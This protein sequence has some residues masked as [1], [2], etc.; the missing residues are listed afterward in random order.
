M[1]KARAFTL[2][3][4][5]VVIAIIALL[6]G[7]LLPA[8]SKARESA[9][10]TICTTNMR[11]VGIAFNTYA[12]DNKEQGWETGNPAPIFRF[13]YAM[14]R[15]QTRA[16]D[17][18][19]N[20]IEIGPGLKYLN[21]SDKPLECPTN[22]RAM[23][24]TGVAGSSN[25]M[26]NDPQ[27][28]VQKVLWEEYLGSRGLN[29]DYTISTGANGLP[30]YTQTRVAY[31]NRTQNMTVSAT[32]TVPPATA[33][34][35]FTAIPIYFEEDTEWWNGKSVDGMFS[36]WDQIAVRH[37]K[38]GNIL[39]L[40]GHVE[41]FKP[42]VG[43]DPLTQGDVGDFTGNDLWVSKGPRWFQ[44]APSWPAVAR[45]YGWAKNPRF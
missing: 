15:N 26:W 4:L 1:V 13:W 11:Q 21:L 16:P 43:P 17:P 23:A 34:V 2:I 8:L 30:L 41:P 31:D 37:A 12:N 9:K 36:N 5:L 32:R 42:T 40:G 24:G 45:P 19:T 22:R 38:K 35:S 3:E 28:A 25:P 14:P 18:T 27:N 20:P 7:I 6:V 10:A 33:L 29:F 39:F 44:Y